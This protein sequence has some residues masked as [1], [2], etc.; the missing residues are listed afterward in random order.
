MNDLE[1]VQALAPQITDVATAVERVAA[2]LDRHI[3]QQEESMTNAVSNAQLTP[4]IA[5]A[6]GADA[7]DFYVAAFGAVEVSRMVDPNGMLMHAEVAIGGQRLMLADE[8][9]DYGNPGPTT[10]GNTTVRLNLHVDD[11]DALAEQAVAA[12]ATLVIPVDDQFY[13]HRSGR[14]RDPFGHEWIISS[15]NEELSVDEMQRR[16]D[17]LFE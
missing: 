7:I 11:V 8:N 16:A 1:A 13:G 17:A 3:H 5:V 10:L 9:P 6:G 12:G 4:Y 14:L 15:T 2:R